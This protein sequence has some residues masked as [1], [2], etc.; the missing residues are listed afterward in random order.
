MAG[1]KK[2]KKKMGLTS[3]IFISLIAGA[4]LGVILHYVVPESYIRDTVLINGIFY[5]VG[6]GFLRLMQMLVVPLVFCSLICGS[7][8]I[9]DTSR[10]KN[11]RLLYAD[12]GAGRR[13][14]AEPCQ[15]H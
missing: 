2:S 13:G 12:D 11:S 10:R 4:I 8:A 5:V 6:N 3:K 15:C 1:K 9:G 7:A 14:G